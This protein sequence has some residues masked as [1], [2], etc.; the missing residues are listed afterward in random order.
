[1]VE[2]D[3]EFLLLLPLF[4]QSWD[5]KSIGSA[6]IEA[7]VSFMLSVHEPRVLLMLSVHSAN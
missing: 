5:Y 2:D 7:S 6:G 1:M 4:P 3:L